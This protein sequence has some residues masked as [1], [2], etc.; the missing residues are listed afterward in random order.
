VLTYRT[1]ANNRPGN[2]IHDDKNGTCVVADVAI[3]GDRIVINKEVEK[4]LKH[5]D[6]VIE[7]HVKC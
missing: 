4:M 2:I 6:F 7:I 3:S 5:E 1:I